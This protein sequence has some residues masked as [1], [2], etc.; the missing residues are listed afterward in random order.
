[1]RQTQRISI[2]DIFKFY[3]YKKN[4]VTTGNTIPQPYIKKSDEVLDDD[5]S[6]DFNQWSDVIEDYIEIITDVLV[7]GKEFKFPNYTG[8]FQLKKYR[9]RKTIDWGSTIK[10]GKKTYFRGE[11]YAIIL[12]WYRDYEI[13]RLQKRFHWK[14]RMGTNLKKA[15]YNKTLQNKNYVYNILDV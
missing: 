8:R 12:K 15:I 14:L 11:S 3:P 2:K 10:S 4:I 1:M 13:T 6:I 5:R 9:T 7:T